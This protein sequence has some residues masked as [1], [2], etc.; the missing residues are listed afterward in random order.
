VILPPGKQQAS[1]SGYS[2]HEAELLKKSAEAGLPAAQ[3]ALAQLYLTRRDSP[4]DL[5]EAYMWYIVATERALQARE[6]VTKMLTPEQVGEAE[7]KANAWIAKRKQPATSSAAPSPR[8]KRSS[9]SADETY[10]RAND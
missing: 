5:V 7:Q 2:R 9:A 3:L 10:S 6:L 4:E 8:S 1:E